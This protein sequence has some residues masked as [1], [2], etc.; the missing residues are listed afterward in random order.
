MYM[1]ICIYIYIYVVMINIHIVTTVMIS[2]FISIIMYC[3][4]PFCGSPFEGQ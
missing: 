1:Y 3:V 2:M 4:F